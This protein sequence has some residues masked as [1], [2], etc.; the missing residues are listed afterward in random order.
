[1]KLSR[2][3]FLKAFL[4]YAAI[5]WGICLVGVFVPA[6]SAF[7]LLGYIGGIAHDLLL[8]DSGW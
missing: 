4:I 6:T 1:M 5:G 8:S 3:S 7:D 2:Y